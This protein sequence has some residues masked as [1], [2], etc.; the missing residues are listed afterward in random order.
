MSGSKVA[1]GTSVSASCAERELPFPDPDPGDW[2]NYASV[3]AFNELWFRKAPKERYDELQDVGTYFHPLDGVSGWNL[4]YGPN[5]FLQ[6]QF[7]VADDRGDV[8]REAIELVGAARAPSF[9]SVLKRFGPANRGLLSFPMAGWTLCLDFPV[10][11]ASLPG[12]VESL[13]ELVDAA[14]GRVY[15]AKDSRVP[16]RRLH[17]MYPRIADLSSVRKRIDP[18]GVL[19][20]DLSRRLAL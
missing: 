11:A 17:H 2:P 3:S 6:Y 19:Q 15:L 13:D 18:D 4:L 14:G 20:S 16:P 5:G 9:V 7:A 12:L 8:V 10:G 1:R